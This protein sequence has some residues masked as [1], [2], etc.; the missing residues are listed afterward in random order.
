[1]TD[2]MELAELLPCPFCGGQAVKCFN[3]QRIEAPMYWVLCRDCHASPG[4]RP[5][6]AEAVTAWNTRTE[7]GG[8]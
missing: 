7:P 2:L 8:V 1:M 5:T 6:E 3:L 4:D